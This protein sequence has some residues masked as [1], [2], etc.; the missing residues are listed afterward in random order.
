VGTVWFGLATRGAPTQ[1]ERL[2]LPG[3][4]SAVRRATVLHALAMLGRV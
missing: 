2:V 1:A 4:R 3:D